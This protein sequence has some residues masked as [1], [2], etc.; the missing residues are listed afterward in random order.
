MVVGKESGCGG[1]RGWGARRWRNVIGDVYEKSG[2]K[3]H[4]LRALGGMAAMI[5]SRGIFVRKQVRLS[6]AKL[7]DPNITTSRDS[8]PPRCGSLP[9]AE[10]LPHPTTPSPARFYA[11]PAFALPVEERVFQHFLLHYGYKHQSIYRNHQPTW[12][13]TVSMS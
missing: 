4:I 11:R 9:F 7:R 10:E 3:L 5:P 1:G 8:W 2:R 13:A 12:R 6:S